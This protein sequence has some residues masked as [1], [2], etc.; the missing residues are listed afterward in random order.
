MTFP[1]VPRD[2][3]TTTL[4]H[5]DREKVPTMANLPGDDFFEDTK[6]SFGQHLEELRVV[7]FRALFGLVIGFLIGLVVANDVVAFIQTPL[8]A[9]L[10]NYYLEKAYQEAEEQPGGVEPEVAARILDDELVPK[11]EKIDPRA[12]IQSLQLAAPD[13]FG[14]L[15]FKPYLFVPDDL[16]ATQAVE[17]CQQL[18][19]EDLDDSTPAGVL[20]NAFDQWEASPRTE[21]VEIAESVS[22]TLTQRHTVTKLLNKLAD[23]PTLH[24]SEALSSV[25]LDRLTEEK[26]EAIRDELKE[27]FDEDESRR[28]NRLLIS[29]AFPDQLRKPRV[30]LISL[31]IWR[32]TEVRVQALSAHE[33]FMIWIKAGFIMGMI[34]ASPW[35]FWQIWLF[36]GAGLYPHEKKFVYMYMPFSMILFLTGAG[37]AFFLV[38]EPV[39]DFLFSFNRAMKIDPDP[40]IGEWIS[41]VL[42]LPLG[43]GIAFQLPLVMVFLNR[44]GIFS[45]EVYLQKWRIAILVIF[46]ASMILTPADPISMLMLAGPLTVLY[47]LGCILCKWMPKSRS[48]FREAYE[49]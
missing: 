26:V 28:L 46:F 42:F 49:P 5:H 41:F 33:S 45:L 43:F 39:L 25:S 11:E 27:A 40:R 30:L 47:F 2:K 14:D 6:M 29:A 19:A 1:D 13:R 12:I 4:H 10:N 15:E 20:A 32:P 3:L 18:T 36:V 17:L 34:I 8:K 24:K 22:A 48:P 31:P 9:A 21:L 35:I 38:F 23:D 37:M 44:I 7:L 16:G